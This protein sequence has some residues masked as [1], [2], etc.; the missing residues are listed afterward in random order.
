M[1]HATRDLGETLAHCR[2]LLAPSG[3][4]IAL[5][6]LQPRA[7]QDLTFGLLDGW[8]RFSDAYRP[9]HALGTAAIWTRALNDTGFSN[10]SFIGPTNPDAG[11]TIGSSVILARGPAEVA[12]SPGTWVIASDEG[13]TATELASE[14][15]ARGQTVI[16]A[17]PIE[18]AVQPSQTGAGVITVNVDIT[19]RRAWESIFGDLPKEVPIKGVVHMMALDGHGAGSTTQE[20][21]E[22]VTR[23]TASALALVQGIAETGVTPTEGVWFVT[24]GAQ[25]IQQDFIDRVPGEL[26][27]ATLWGFGKVDGREVAHLQPRIG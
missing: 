9:D 3:Q 20:M 16:L 24:R 27:G 17:C 21:A 23:V 13:G 19:Q 6:G 7:Y 4:L 10:V 12:L 11:R 15:T 8:W 5:E 26:A 18:G 14:L 25:L 1:L 22:D 2:D